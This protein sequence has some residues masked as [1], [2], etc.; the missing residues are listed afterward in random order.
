M[1][2]LVIGHSVLDFINDGSSVK[3]K[4]G[5]IHYSISALNR[6]SSNEDEI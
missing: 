1:K 5:G 4:A 2:L 6:L 3:Q